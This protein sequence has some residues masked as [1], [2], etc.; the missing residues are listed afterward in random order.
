MCKTLAI[1]I[2]VKTCSTYMDAQ[3]FDDLWVN[4]YSTGH[5]NTVTKSPQG[6]NTFWTSCLLTTSGLEKL[7]ID[8]GGKMVRKIA[9][10]SRWERL[11]LLAAGYWLAV[12]IN[13]DHEKI[14]IYSPVKPWRYWAFMGSGRIMRIVGLNPLS[15]PKSIILRYWYRGPVSCWQTEPVDRSLSIDRYSRKLSSKCEMGLSVNFW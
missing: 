6:L 3:L 15:T 4:I 10:C 13:D 11:D 1:S 2:L 14:L 5:A 7:R 8:W 9:R 12:Q